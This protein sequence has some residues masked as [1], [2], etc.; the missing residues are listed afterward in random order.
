MSTP[1]ASRISRRTIATGAAWSAPAIAVTMA[2]PYAAAS[3][4]TLAIVT[5]SLPV[6]YVNEPLTVPLAA[7]GGTSPYTWSLLGGQVP[8]GTVLAPTGEISG[9]PTAVGQFTATVAVADQGGATANTDVVANVGTD[10]TAAAAQMLSLINDRRT[11]IGLAPLTPTTTLNAIATNWAEHLAS[12]GSSLVHQSPLPA[13]VRGENLSA[14]C[15]STPVTSS[16]VTVGSGLTNRWLAEKY[17]YAEWYA[18]NQTD[19][20]AARDMYMGT[21]AYAAFGASG[22][23]INIENPNF[24]TI[25][26]GLA[27]SASGSACGS[28]YPYGYYG[29][30][31]FG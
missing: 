8:P 19:P 30:A 24:T 23:R 1:D 31:E 2:A 13:G 5:A 15:S 14:T 29:A 3:P 16:A 27:Y 21:G 11:S 20:A 28:S 6:S 4:A 22:H 18:L 12:T 7:T 9:S 17:S 25:G 10:R 26:V